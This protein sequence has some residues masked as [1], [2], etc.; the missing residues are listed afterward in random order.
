[1]S[2]INRKPVTINDLKNNILKI[3][4]NPK[5]GT[6]KIYNKKGKILMKQTNLT[7]DQIKNIEE[8]ILG[9]ITKKINEF[10]IKQKTD[11]KYDPMVA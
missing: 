6:I 9:S 4:S 1:M 2:I 3:V 11:E 10:K 5:R 7:I 8:T